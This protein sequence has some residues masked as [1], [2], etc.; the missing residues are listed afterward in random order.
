MNHRDNLIQRVLLLHKKLTV[1]AIAKRLGLPVKQVWE[2]LQ[3]GLL[4]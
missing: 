4:E 3:D 2:L 1:R